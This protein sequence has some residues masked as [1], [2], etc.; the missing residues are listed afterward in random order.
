MWDLNRSPDHNDDGADT[1]GAVAGSVAAELVASSSS[2]SSARRCKYDVFLSF[3]GPDTRKGITVEIRDQLQSRDVITFM[4][5]RGLEPGD[6]ISRKLIEAIEE[7][8][9]AIVVLSPNYASSTWCLEELAKICEC[10]EDNRI[11]PLFYNVEPS[12]VRHQKKRS[13]GEA[14]SKHE[15]SGRHTS[16]KIQLWRDA[17]EKVASLTGWDSNNFKTERELVEAVVD[18][19]CKRIQPFDVEFTMSTGDFEEFGASRKAMDEVMKAL[20]DDNV[21]AIGVYGM[22]GVGKTTLVKHV[23]EKC[24]KS[25]IFHDVI[26]AVVSQSL[27]LKKITRHIGRSAGTLRIKKEDRSWKSKKVA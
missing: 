25:G 3:R 15:T 16:K 7:S 17:L 21:T 14:F 18:S 22:G 9:F 26:M 23:A 2:S 10:M 20:I 8:R 13:F 19:V 5:D 24:R 12:N 6:P 11:L 27:D 1:P 4:D